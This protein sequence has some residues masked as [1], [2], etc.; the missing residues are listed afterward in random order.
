MYME[1]IIKILTLFFVFTI[2]LNICYAE[3]VNE[4]NK[5]NETN[6]AKEV[7]SEKA[8]LESSNI[9]KIDTEKSYV[10][11]VIKVGAIYENEYKYQEV[12]VKMLEG[13]MKDEE[14]D[15]KYTLKVLDTA[16]QEPLEVG[17]KVYVIFAE[18]ENVYIPSISDVYR[19]P[20]LIF[21]TVL[22]LL[23]II[24][25]GRFQGVKTVISLLVT[26]FAIFCIMIPRVINGASAVSSSIVTCIIIAIITFVLISGFK[27]KTLVAILGTMFGVIVAGILSS[28]VASLG[29]ITGL[30]DCEAHMLV[31]V[32][33]SMNIDIDGMLFAGILIRYCRSYNGCCNEHSISYDRSIR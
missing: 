29:H 22:F 33:Q 18:G 32:S 30:A 10:A 25:I 31:Y 5:E 9:E 21:I 24:I 2:V 20:Y 6:E 23:L 27:R 1:K 7:T 16:E 19:L 26:I 15:I 13:V 14:Y 8:N 3:N 28:V 17:E 11:K 12:T 4:L